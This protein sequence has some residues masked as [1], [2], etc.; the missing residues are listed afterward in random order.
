LLSVL[1]ETPKEVIKMS[2]NIGRTNVNVQKTEVEF[3]GM[4]DVFFT[5]LAEMNKKYISIRKENEMLLAKL[6]GAGV[7]FS[8]IQRFLINRAKECG[9]HTMSEYAG[10][11]KRRHRTFEEL[12]RDQPRWFVMILRFVKA[13]Q[14]KY[15]D[16]GIEKKKVVPVNLFS[17]QPDEGKPV[18]KKSNKNGVSKGQVKSQIVSGSKDHSST[19]HLEEAAGLNLNITAPVKEELSLLQVQTVILQNLDVLGRIAKAK[20]AISQFNALMIAIGAEDEVIV[21][22]SITAPVQYTES[23]V[24]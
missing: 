15:S 14:S 8:D 24:Q 10:P 11:G 12:K 4:G 16:Y 20:G 3:S 22:D 1:Y 6:R 13:V 17:K 7:A 19:T 2:E 21:S 9:L 5:H 18:V 23:A